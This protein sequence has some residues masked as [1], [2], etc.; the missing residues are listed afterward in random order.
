MKKTKPVTYFLCVLTVAFALVTPAV[1]KNGISNFKPFVSIKEEEHVE[2][3]FTLWHIAGF[4]S[5]G[6]TI[7]SYLSKCVKNFEKSHAYSFIEIT[8][9]TVEEAEARLAAGEQPDLISF[10]CGFFNSNSS[11][12]QT[13]PYL[14]TTYLLYTNIT[15]LSE[16]G[17]DTLS[18]PEFSDADIFSAAEALSS[19]KTY[20][21]ALR[22]ETS[23][24]PAAALCFFY[25][26]ESE[27]KDYNF[28]VTKDASAFEKGKAAFMIASQRYLIALSSASFELCALSPFRFTDLVQYMGVYKN[29]DKEAEALLKEFASSLLNEKN[30]TRAMLAGCPMILGENIIQTP[31]V[32]LAYERVKLP[33]LFTYAAAKDIMIKYT[34]DMKH[35]HTR[36]LFRSLIDIE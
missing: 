26:N 3:I 13:T 30:Q 17:I 8:S 35:A 4:Q 32:A 33:K 14:F 15:L 16:E 36:E 11:F 28:S 34:E 22:A 18:L 12:A 21:F 25:L 27:T 24:C 6:E 29:E 7:S 20:G 1:I 9:M 31:E 2:G 23:G 19:D 10:P 5:D